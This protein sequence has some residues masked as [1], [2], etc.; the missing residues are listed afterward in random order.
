LG[1]L[2]GGLTWEPLSIFVVMEIVW[3]IAAGGRWVRAHAIG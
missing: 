1:H 2:V 3:A